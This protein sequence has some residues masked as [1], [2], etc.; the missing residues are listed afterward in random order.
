MKIPHSNLRKLFRLAVPN[1]VFMRFKAV[2][3]LVIML[4]V[5][6]APALG[7]TTAKEWFDKGVALAEQS[8]YDEAIEPFDK[9][10][11]LDPNFGLAWAG[12]GIVLGTQV[13]SLAGKVIA[14]GDE[15][16]VDQAIQAFD[17]AIELDPNNASVYSG[18]RGFLLYDQGKYDEAI[19]AFDKVN[20]QDANV[21]YGKGVALRMLQRH[22]AAD[23]AFKKARELGYSGSMTIYEMPGLWK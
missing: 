8:R 3:V 20:P 9:A 2:F 4:I 1:K 17:K 19:Q 7:Q 16:Q 21:W 5:L 6:C 12:K 23:A 18:A 14:P 22:S 13:G 10:I 11:E 15:G